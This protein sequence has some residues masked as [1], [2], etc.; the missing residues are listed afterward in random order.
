MIDMIAINDF[1]INTSICPSREGVIQGLSTNLPPYLWPS[2]SRVINL[3]RTRKRRKSELSKQAR[4]LS[5]F[6]RSHQDRSFR[7]PESQLHS[8]QRSHPHAAQRPTH[9]FAGRL[10]DSASY[11]Y[12]PHD[13]SVRIP[14]VDHSCI[15]YD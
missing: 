15:M 10:T 12:R 9:A 13:H 4:V 11:M 3:R 1:A 14:C 6:H 7:R 5:N 2:I 8:Y